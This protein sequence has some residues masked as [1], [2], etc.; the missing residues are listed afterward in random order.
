MRTL[1][2]ILV[3]A[4]VLLADE[5]K[6]NVTLN[7]PAPGLSLPSL[8]DERQ[9]MSLRDFVE[10]AR[11][12]HRKS[13]RPVILAFWS[14]SCVPCRKELPRLQVWADQHS[15]VLFWPILVDDAAKSVPGVQALERLGVHDL[16]L[17]DLYQVAGERY[18]VC[19]HSLC[20]VPALVVVG[21][22]G[23]VRLAHQGFDANSDLE[24]QLNQ[25]LR[26]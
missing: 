19:K 12:A 6:L 5:G 8:I 24:A 18:G 11:C 10:P 17:H 21:E 4:A 3:L 2:T 9:R 23:N 15:N 16:G 1:M 20:N 13:C 22:D 25:A 7:Q 26:R 14:T